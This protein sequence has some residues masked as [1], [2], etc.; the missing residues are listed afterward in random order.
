MDNRCLVKVSYSN[1]IKEKGLLEIQKHAE[2]NEKP[3]PCRSQE[4]MVIHR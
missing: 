2:G 4:G 3:R 1:N